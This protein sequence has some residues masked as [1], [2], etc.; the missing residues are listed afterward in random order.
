MKVELKALVTKK[1]VRGSKTVDSS[2]IQIR[3]NNLVFIQR[4]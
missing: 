2:W 3:L 1:T 4:L